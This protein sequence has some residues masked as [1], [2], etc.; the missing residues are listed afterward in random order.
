MT[1]SVLKLSMLLVQLY[2]QMYKKGKRHMSCFTQNQAQLVRSGC[3]LHNCVAGIQ[4]CRQS[5]TVRWILYALML[6][7]PQAAVPV[8]M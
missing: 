3:D 2:T 4:V 8:N 6:L 7:H 5:S 1:H